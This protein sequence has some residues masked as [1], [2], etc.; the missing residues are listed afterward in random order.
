MTFLVATYG[1]KHLGMLLAHLHA[2]R[3]THPAAKIEVYYQD[4]STAQGDAIRRAHLEVTFIET[5][6]DFAN[7]RILRISSKTLAWEQA[8]LRRP[9]G[10][11]F[12]LLDVDTL[13]CKSLAPF[14][15]EA[16]FDVLFT[17]K[18]SGFVLNTGVLLCRMNAATR[19]FFPHWR[20]ETLAI[21]RDPAR[22]RRANDPHEPF[23]AADQMALHEMLGYRAAQTR[24]AID[25]GGERVRFR[26]EPCEMLNETRSCPITERTHIIH[27]KGGWQPILLDGRR[28]S[29]HRSRADCWEMYR[30]YLD[31]FREAL[32]RLNA[33]LG[34]RWQPRD[35]HLHIP[36]YFDEPRPWRQRLLYLGHVVRD[37]VQEA[38]ALS[39]G[40]MRLL[41]RK[42]KLCR[43]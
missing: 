21:L 19:A 17:W 3:R 13:V 15:A 23:G 4:W 28:F 22:F 34:A 40:A 14:F 41:S 29:R 9:E 33:T 12:C 35:F 43:S 27:F 42:L 32:D 1:A 36:R 31:T 10:E 16:D 30:Y 8:A 18:E 5:H 37:Y 20:E 24:Y 2:L 6:F 25:I 38:L 39:R 7:D 11:D 26:G